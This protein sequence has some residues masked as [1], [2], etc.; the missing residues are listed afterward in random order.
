MHFLKELPIRT[1]LLILAAATIFVM[2]IIIYIPYN[3]ISMT[4][5][6]NNSQFSNELISQTQ[7]KISAVFNQINKIAFSI[8]YNQIIQEA[9]LETDEYKK[10][11]SDELVSSYLT[12]LK[13]LNEGIID[14][15][16]LGDNGNY[17][18]PKTR[19]ESSRK[20]AETFPEKLLDKRRAVF[21]EMKVINLDGKSINCFAVSLE[22]YY[23]A[24]EFK[25]PGEEN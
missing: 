10:V 14:I 11:K 17:Y 8:A 25:K 13:D 2:I 1:Q 7:N 12:N 18:C 5:S 22:I 21:S 6:R 24:G 23:K 15:V 20:I 9:L 19:W 16:A 3:K 4:I